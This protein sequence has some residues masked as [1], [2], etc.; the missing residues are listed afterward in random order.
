MEN[1]GTRPLRDLQN[2]ASAGSYGRFESNIE[3]D[4]MRR[5]FEGTAAWHY[6]PALVRLISIPASEVPIHHVP[7]PIRTRDR[8]SKLW[9]TETRTA[10][11]FKSQLSPKSAPHTLNPAI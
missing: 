3:R 7:V 5:S 8:Q 9:R 4:V 1:Q 2:L 6:H 11:K 10:Y